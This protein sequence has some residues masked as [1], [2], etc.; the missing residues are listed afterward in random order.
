[1][2]M[3]AAVPR[4]YTDHDCAPE[5]RGTLLGP[6]VFP[7][8][9]IEQLFLTE[10]RRSGAK[11]ARLAFLAGA[12]TALSFSL[13]MTAVPER[14]FDQ[15]ER[16]FIRFALVAVLTIAALIVALCPR[17]V[18]RHYVLAVGAPAALAC[19][20][21]AGLG[22]L[23]V[24]VDLPR[25]GRMTVAMCLTCYLVYGFA[26]LPPGAVAAVCSLA[27]I[28]A[29]AASIASG[30]D[31]PH[32]L[33]IYLAV[34]NLSGWILAVQIE[35]R[36]RDVFGT[37][38]ALTRGRAQ[39]ELS[40]QASAEA[41]AAKSHVL[42]AVSH[43]LRQPLASISLYLLALRAATGQGGCVTAGTVSQIG[44]CVAAMTDN[45]S[46]LS[47]IA[48]LR[49]RREFF[50]IEAVDLRLLLRRLASVYVGQASIAG[51][52]LVVAVPAPG[53]LVVQSNGAR[54]WEVLSNLASNAVKFRHG[55][56]AAWVLVRATRIG[57]DLRIAILD[58]GIGID[59]SF[60]RRVFDE[61]FQVGNRQR[62]RAGGYGLG[63]PI[64]RETVSRLP[65]HRLRMRSRAGQGSRFDVFVPGASKQHGPSA[66]A[67]QEDDGTKHEGAGAAPEGAGWL[68]EGAGMPLRL[69]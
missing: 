67:G 51:V 42:A 35:K 31:Y 11:F 37:T 50:P 48:E 69:S 55:A 56:R 49:D 62:D 58:N 46:R 13:L 45:L 7:D 57:D 54:L 12:G 5:R 16:Q 6:A 21:V 2:S 22:F 60:H 20:T 68:G 18:A 34:T 8:A 23:P 32:A 38:L 40:A 19:L 1:M 3:R 41:N 47:N 36:E 39:L 29:I 24:E 25:S 17:F 28:V 43:D 59:S 61:Y 44:E 15:H 52:R 64:V 63:L 53:K 26:R 30:D 14:Y 33:A 4:E 66:R 10:F 65:G 9:T 27:S